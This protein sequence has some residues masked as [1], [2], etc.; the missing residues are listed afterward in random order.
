MA[1][2]ITELLEVI[3]GNSLG[4]ATAIQLRELLESRLPEIESRGGGDSELALDEKDA[5]VITYGDQFRGSREPP[6]HYLHS[7]AMERLKEVVSGIHIL[8]F[9]PFSSDDGFSIIDYREVNPDFGQWKHVDEIGKDFK[10]MSDLVLNHCSA[11]SSWFREFLRG[12]EDYQNYFIT[13]PRGTDVSMIVRPRALPLLTPF[14]T[15]RGEELVWTTFSDDQVDLNFAEPKVLLEMIDVFLFHVAHG[16]QVIRLDAIA[17]VW[18]EL[19]HPSIHHD[20]THAIVKLFRAVVDRYLPWVIILTETNVPHKENISYFGN[21]SDEAHMIYQFSL[22]PLV[23]DAFIREDASHLKKWAGELP[24][25][26]GPITY[27]NFLAS[28]DGVGL[29]PTHGILSEAEIKNLLS[30]VDRRGGLI[31]YKA[32]AE[33]KIPYEANINYREAIAEASLSDA[34]KVRKF[35]ASQ[36]VMLSMVGVPGIY[37]HSLL[38]SGNFREGVAETGMNR[39]INREKLD[40]DTLRRELEEP[41]SLRDGIFNGFI[42]MLS[43]RRDLAAFHPRGGQQIIATPGSL[44]CVKRSSVDGAEEILCLI[45]VGSGKSDL[46]IKGEDLPR[47]IG[48][49]EPKE[50]WDLISGRK[51]E[52]RENDRGRR[53]GVGPWEVLWISG[54]PPGR[55]AR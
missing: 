41:N 21:G 24:E 8:P 54:S 25:I 10:L 40:F 23:L 45:N 38:G 29:T 51:L 19:G 20:K 50:L 53:I 34:E 18:K 30:E 6:L 27:F 14:E 26:E 16:I 42:N 47:S 48:L 13:V 43:I 22:P 4:R 37:V 33:S 52:S 32:T 2:R 15:T 3:Y 55:K 49:E 46:T 9:F 36:A 35:L 11:K 28:H 39:T 5:F 1:D 7:F 17:Y 31:S 44:F 12:S